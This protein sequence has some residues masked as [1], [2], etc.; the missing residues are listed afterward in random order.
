MKRLKSFALSEDEI[1]TQYFRW[2]FAQERVYPELRWVCHIPNG[3][4]RHPL[5][6]V[7]LKR[8]GI[9]AGVADV[10]IPNPNP[11][12]ASKGLWIEFKSLNGKQSSSQKSFTLAMSLSGYKYEIC[13][14]SQAAIN[15]TKSYLRI[16]N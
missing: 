13:R 9:R 16:G 7:K 4:S 6:A 2:V 10:F 8:M 5:E 12:A 1:Q 3:G 14:T 15:L 11:F